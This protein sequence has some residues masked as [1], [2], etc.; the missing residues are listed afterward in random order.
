[1]AADPGAAVRPRLTFLLWG[2]PALVIWAC[3]F[4]FAFDVAHSVWAARSAASHVGDLGRHVKAGRFPAAMDDAHEAELD[5]RTVR[6]AFDG[7]LWS[8]AAHV[9][10]LGRNVVAVRT[11]AAALDE[12]GQHALPVA[13]RLAEQVHDRPL[14]NDSGTFDLDALAGLRPRAQELVAALQAP[15]RRMDRLDTGGLFPLLGPQVVRL[16]EGMDAAGSGSSALAV[17]STIGPAL[18]GADGPRTYLVVV[19]NNAEI[20]ATGGLPGSFLLL[21][22]RNGRIRLGGQQFGADLRIYHQPVL[23]LTD[24]ERRLYGE[25]LGTDVRDANLTPSFPRAAQLLRARMSHDF[26]REV[27]GVISVDPVTLSYLMRTT[28]PIDVAGRHLTDDNVVDVLLHDTYQRIDDVDEQDA[29]FAQV[30]HK[31]FAVLTE[32]SGDEV[33]WLRQLGSA[34]AQRRVLLWSAHPEEQRVIEPSALS[35]DMVSGDGP[36]PDVGFYLDNAANG[37]MEYFLDLDAALESTG[38]AADGTQTL[39][40]RM[41]LQ[42]DAP[43]DVSELGRW[44]TGPGTYTARGNIKVNLRVYGPRGGTITSLRANGE[45]LKVV[46]AEHDG[47]PVAL[48]TVVLEPGDEVDIQATLRTAAGRRGDPTFAWTPGIRTTRSETRAPSACD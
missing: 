2:L 13:V 5:L 10:W 17:V 12:A 14:R 45:P 44:V 34:A 38:C 23:P 20:R 11:S 30:A 42:S 22:A 32:G 4:L 36:D 43:S 25:N 27:D 1:M 24:A 46:G 26:G 8:A 29:F 9:P 3:A 41:S 37:K 40:A 7:P 28:G 21:H 33:G 47:H 39:R 18:L 48:V 19:Q 35:G 6:R 16:Q 15:R 31:V